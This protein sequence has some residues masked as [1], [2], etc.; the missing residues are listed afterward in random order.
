MAKGSL[1]AGMDKLKPKPKSKQEKWW[2]EEK[3]KLKVSHNTYEEY[4]VEK[5]E[6]RFKRPVKYTCGTCLHK[7]YEAVRDGKTGYISDEELIESS[8]NMLKHR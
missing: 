7:A 2:D 5:L 6:A 8:N 3:R 1:Q 4:C